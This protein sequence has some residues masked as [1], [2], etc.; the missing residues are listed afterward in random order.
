[1]PKISIVTDTDSSMPVSLAE[2]Y[3]ILAG[4]NLNQFW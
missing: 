1:M 2:K 3:G 4:P